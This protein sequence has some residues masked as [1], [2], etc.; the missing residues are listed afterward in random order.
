MRVLTAGV[1]IGG[2]HV[3]AG[4]VDPRGWNIVS[5]WYAPLGEARGPGD[6]AAAV[7]KVL[8]G[9]LGDFRDSA[10]AVGAFQLSGVGIGVPALIRWPGCRVTVAPNLGWRDVD[11]Q[12][13]LVSA[14]TAARLP[15]SAERVLIENDANL[16]ALGEWS[17]GA[18]RG[19]KV[20]VCITLGT[21]IG[22][23]IVVDGKVFRGAYGLAGEIGH[24]KVAPSGGSRGEPCGCGGKGCL[25]AVSSG[26][27]IVR[28]A[29]EAGVPGIQREAGAKQVFDAA[30]KG[31]AEA[32]RI[33]REAGQ[34]LGIGLAHV[35]CVLDPDVIVL[36]GAMA[37]AW[38]AIVEP[39]IREMK[40]L[41]P[42]D[43]GV[44]VESAALGPDAGI[45]GGAALCF[46]PADLC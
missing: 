18:A 8:S 7:A 27:A 13:I 15:V 43:A 37:A 22:G 21:G 35:A 26:S 9:C 3:S 33:I 10:S 45:I 24:L 19:A 39:A 6:V 23:G 36:G 2:S 16:A 30:R 46:A 1:D 44:R 11:I 34:Y 42:V 41:L 32:A 20:A 14:I 31:N 38:D 5:R 4:I 25:E 12:P 28:R 29:I 40:T 17:A